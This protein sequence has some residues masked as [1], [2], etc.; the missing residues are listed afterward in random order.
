MSMKKY[1][2]LLSYSMAVISFSNVDARQMPSQD[3]LKSVPGLV[4]KTHPEYYPNGLHYHS[5]R[6]SSLLSRR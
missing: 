5:G 4:Y 1:V 6:R 3:E 2:F